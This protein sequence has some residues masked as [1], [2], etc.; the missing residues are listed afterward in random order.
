M[1]LR[2]AAPQ[3][4]HSV[5]TR[6]HERDQAGLLRQLADPQPQVRRHAAR[7]LAAH[8][9]A[10][11]ALGRALAA[12]ADAAVREALFT[13]LTSLASEPAAQALVPLLRSEDAALRNGAI[14]ALA[15]MPAA[16]A[17]CMDRLLTDVD[18][19]VRIFAVNLLG[20]LRHPEVP[21]WLGQVLRQDTQVNVVAAAVEVL[22]EVGSAQE[23]PA[24]RAARERFAGEAFI[25]FAIEL[26]ITRIEAS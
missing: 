12:E 16:A 2:K 3:A 9:D 8:P 18:A 25:D 26:A 23:L 6:Q 19:D 10:A 11:E 21:R 7:D 14:E 4:L 15:G 5:Q 13:S 17:A 24:L 1:A 20:E 22:T